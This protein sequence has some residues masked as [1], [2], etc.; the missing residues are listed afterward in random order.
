MEKKCQCGGKMIKSELIV[1]IMPI[2]TVRVPNGYNFPKDYQ[3]IPFVCE[4][5]GKIELYAGANENGSIMFGG[6][7]VG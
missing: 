3:V 6:M 2:A 1:G 5:C 4:K 7:I